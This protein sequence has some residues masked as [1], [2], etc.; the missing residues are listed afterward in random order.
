MIT[1]TQMD[2]FTTISEVISGVLIGPDVSS[3]RSDRYEAHKGASQKA[4]EE[5]AMTSS[6][7]DKVLSSDN[8][9]ESLKA[10]ISVL[11]ESLRALESAHAIL[12]AEFKTQTIRSSV[13]SQRADKQAQALKDSQDKVAD[14]TAEVKM[15]KAE[16]SVLNESLRE[17]END[18]MVAFRKAEEEGAKTSSL[19]IK[20]SRSNNAIESLKAE[21]SVLNESLRALESAH[22]ILQAEFKT[23]LRR[24]AARR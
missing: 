9:I 22:A 3:S 6:L 23:K 24:F 14:L 5:R 8:T 18:K 16:I 13:A 2:F 15:L 1:A 21:I 11:N 10:K 4:Q 20:V 17:L 19:E 7:K 12:Q